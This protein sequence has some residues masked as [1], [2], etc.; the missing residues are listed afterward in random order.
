MTVNIKFR[1]GFNPRTYI[2]YDKVSIASTSNETSFNPRTYIRY[3]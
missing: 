1:F 3:D 2:R